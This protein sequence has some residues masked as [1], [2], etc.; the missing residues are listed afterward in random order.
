M[1]SS[2]TQSTAKDFL[3]DIS[4]LISLEKKAIA[5]RKRWAGGCVLIGLS[6]IV[7]ALFLYAR[8]PGAASQIIG[9]GG[10][11]IGALASFP[12]REISVGSLRIFVYRQL[13]RRFKKF[14]SLSEEERR[15]L[16]DRFYEV[17]EKQIS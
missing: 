5:S 8:N 12:V 10:L 11:F 9:I 14:L 1:T 2:G 16:I 13:R 3:A 6:I 4:E 7:L 17:I 15:Q